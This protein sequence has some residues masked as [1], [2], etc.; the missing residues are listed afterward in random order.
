M[1]GH[2]IMMTPTLFNLISIRSQRT[3]GF[4]VKKQPIKNSW[5]RS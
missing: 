2:Q 5:I 1:S 3:D 4:K